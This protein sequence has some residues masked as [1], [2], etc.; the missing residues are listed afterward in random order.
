M[1]A[2]SLHREL[3]LYVLAGLTPLEAIRAATVLPAQ[4][5]GLAEVA[6]PFGR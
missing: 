1:P 3:E 4:A 2:H 5:M 6:A